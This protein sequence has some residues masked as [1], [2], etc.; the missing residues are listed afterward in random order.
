MNFRDSVCAVS[1]THLLQIFL[2][3]ILAAILSFFLYFSITAIVNG[4]STH[5]I[6]YR[7]Y[8]YD[9]N[10]QPVLVEEGSLDEE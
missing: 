9:E 5:A 10:S 3:T 8:E 4:L 1:Y 2:R 7:I 6:G